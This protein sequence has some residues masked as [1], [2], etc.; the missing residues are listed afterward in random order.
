MRPRDT[1]IHYLRSLSSAWWLYAI[2]FLSLLEVIFVAYPVET[3]AMLP[4][5][6]IIGLLLLG[7]FPGYS[8]SRML[9]PG[10]QLSDLER[11]L[12]S[13]FLSVTISITI[14]VILGIGY[15]FTGMASVVVSVAY[16]GFSTL[17]GAYR[18]YSFLSESASR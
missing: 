17:L 15:W 18:R 12:L 1:F 14:G 6:I 7:Y 10:D 5:R 4:M 9:F 2:L 13:V 3:S 8:T 11:I 16:T